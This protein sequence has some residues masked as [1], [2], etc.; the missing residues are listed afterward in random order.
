MSASHEHHSRHLT[1]AIVG[2][3][4]VASVAQYTC[5]MHPQIVR[6][7]PGKCPICGMALE[8][9]MPGMD[10]ADENLERSDFR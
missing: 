7:A 5:L 6:D 8:P 1:P 3:E 2:T 9:M 4:K 10:D